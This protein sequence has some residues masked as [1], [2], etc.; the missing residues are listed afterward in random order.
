MS[1]LYNAGIALYSLAARVAALRPG[2]ARRL[3]EGH[4]Q[5]FGRLARFAGGVEGANASGFDVWFH[6][7]SVGEFEQA[8]P[9]IERIRREHP[10]WKILLSFFSPSGFDLRKNYDKVDCVVY[11][12]F[13]TPDNA[14]RFVEAVNPRVAIFV[15]YE[16]WGNYLTELKRRGV[17]TYIISAI[18]RP[19][20]RFFSR[21]GGMWRRLL[22]CFTHLYVQDEASA[23]LL[24]GIG[25]GNVTVAGDTRFDRV[26]AVRS[27]SLDMPYLE[28]WGRGMSGSRGV[29]VVAGSSWEADEDIYFRWLAE[30]PE[31]KVI[32]APHEFDDARIAVLQRSVP[33]KSAL[34]TDIME[35]GCIDGDVRAVIVN[36]FGKL[37]SLYRCGHVALI[38]GG[39]GAG[40][41]NI[42]EAAV[43][44]MPVVFGPKH[45]KFKEASDL[46]A[47]GG[48]FEYH[49]LESLSAVMS[50]LCGSKEALLAAS[51]VSEKYI[52]EN[53][54]AT[55]KIYNLIFSENI[56]EK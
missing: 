15:K 44:G 33:G 6:A 27:Q 8:R 42:N 40:I 10:D 20:Q 26:A 48:G 30:H 28:E 36:C 1:P 17:P 4:G 9:M 12:P 45:G 31:A 47:L 35:A 54:G 22:G 18:F 50:H 11:L 41:H 29:T 24:R 53:I 39:F 37:S 55:D 34:L 16:F 49:D 13:D 32:I 25:I 38:G 7:A 43:Y 51:A 52:T 21:F 19:G 46:I 23:G 14:R 56:F 2:K 5:T 3:V